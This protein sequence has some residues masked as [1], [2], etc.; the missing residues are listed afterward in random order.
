MKINNESVNKRLEEEGIYYHHVK[1]C[2]DI[3]YFISLRKQVDSLTK[4][5]LC[6]VL[7]RIYKLTIALEVEI[8]IQGYELSGRWMVKTWDLPAYYIN[9]DMN[10]AIIEC[11]EAIG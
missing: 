5:H 2:Y 4:E 8:S 11:V 10:D 7:Q 3:V 6:N 9:K 1:D